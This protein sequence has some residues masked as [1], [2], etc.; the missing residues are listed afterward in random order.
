MPRS[1]P[2][3][4]VMDALKD[5]MALIDRRAPNRADE[6]WD[7]ALQYEVAVRLAE[8]TRRAIVAIGKQGER[9]LARERH[10]RLSL[11]AARR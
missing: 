8:A 11:E 9:R 10:R 6:R 2:G 1:K 3:N 7:A 4:R 5:I